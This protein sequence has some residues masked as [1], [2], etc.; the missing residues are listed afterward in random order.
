MKF[1]TIREE[2]GH[3][4]RVMTRKAEWFMDRIKRDTA[5]G[6][7]G[8]YRQFV[9]YSGRVGTYRFMAD[10]PRLCVT[11]ELRASDTGVPEFV[12]WNGLVPIEVHELANGEACAAVKRA[13]MQQ[14][15]TWAAVTGADGQSVVVLV[16]VASAKGHEPDNEADAE[17]L[18]RAAYRTL[19]PV[20]DALLQTPA[21]RME[22]ELR[23]T[24]LLP[25]D[26]APL[27]N[28]DAV[29]FRIVPTDM[30][31]T[32][33]LAEA[34][35]ALERSKSYTEPDMD[36]YML[37]SRLYHRA[38]NAVSQQ[39]TDAELSDAEWWHRFLNGVAVQ[40]YAFDLS[41]EEAV[42]QIWAALRYGHDPLVTEELVRTVVAAVYAQERAIRRRNPEPPITNLMH[43]LIHRIDTRYVL[44]RNTVMGYAEYRP[45]NSWAVPWQP[46]TDE[47]V[48]TM[49][50]D[51][52][53][54]GLDVWD[55][56]VRRYIFSTR[57]PVYDPVQDYLGS[58]R[59]KWDGHDHIRD[60]ARTVPTAIGRQWADWFHTWFLGMVHQWRGR[61]LQY[62][63]SVVPL[64][65]S[66]Q[67]MHKS[68][69][70]RNLLPPELRTWGY[71]DNLSLAEER[72]VHQAMAQMLL[73]NL[74]EFNR[75]SPK[76]Q[77]GFLKNIVQLPSVKVKRPYGRHIEEVPRLASFIATTNMAD[78]LA[79]PGGSRRFIGVQVTGCIDVSR[80]PNYTQLYAQAVAE[81]DSH[82]PHWFDDAE[83]AAIMRHNQQFQITPSAFQFFLTYFEPGTGTDG[84][85]M[86]AAAIL[87][88]VKRRAGAA[89]HD[90]PTLNSFGRFL[91]SMQA[92]PAKQT[93]SGRMYLV[94]AVEE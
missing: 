58:V 80:Q 15:S 45:N 25:W 33:P 65:I 47:V 71:T 44:R 64:L 70:C 82:V 1:S 18:L 57:V 85:W 69:F 72:P 91:A 34:L 48:N 4:V 28:P 30:A 52:Q 49:T 21:A 12:A 39:M 19:L 43:S 84:R 62:G 9:S 32:R 11:C 88:E 86:T 89:L 92:L 46:V 77:E 24:I 2:K 20:Y 75:I 93:N 41:E 54:G 35:P 94:K 22:P 23:R 6:V 73:I 63:N 40:L 83:T 26:E 51:L 27:W 66:A 59:D 7:V 56:D 13:A 31:D 55:R 53:L 37:H 60:L 16:R 5:Q 8:G 90:L 79:D 67:G 38:V 87:A 3:R 81:L 78:V 10:I 76:V 61:R 36:A 68:T 14:P 50:A 42:C 74:D 29:P 17:A